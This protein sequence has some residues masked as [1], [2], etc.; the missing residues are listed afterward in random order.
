MEVRPEWDLGKMRELRFVVL[1]LVIS[2]PC[3]SASDRQGTTELPYRSCKV[4]LSSAV[5]SCL[6]IGMSVFWVP[7]S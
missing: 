4:T 1:V 7:V 2:L 6:C 5:S 3:F